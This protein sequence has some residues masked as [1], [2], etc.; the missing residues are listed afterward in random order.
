MTGSDKYERA[1][2]VLHASRRA[3]RVRIQELEKSDPELRDLIAAN[4]EAIIK[5][6]RMEER[7]PTGE[8]PDA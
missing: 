6:Q 4:V 7:T 1:L 2:R 8:R 3:M 5:I